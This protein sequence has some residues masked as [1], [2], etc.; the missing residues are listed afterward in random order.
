MQCL[1]AF[2]ADAGFLTILVQDEVAGLEALAADGTWHLVRP[3][4]GALT[5]NVG[6]L[7]RGS[8][9]CN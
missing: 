7:V 6:D 9:L 1:L 4:D 5:I 2:H 3:I 8:R